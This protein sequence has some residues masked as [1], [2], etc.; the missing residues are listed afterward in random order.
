MA[1]R[2]PLV[3]VN[4]QIQQLQAGDNISDPDFLTLTND[5]AGS[6]PIGTPVYID[7]DD[8]A[9]KARANAAATSNVRALV[10]S[11]SISNG[12]SGS[13][14]RDGVLVATTGQWDTITGGSGGLVFNTVYYLDPSTAG[15]LTDTAPTTVGQLVVQVGVAL[16]TTEL[17][18]EIE[19]PILL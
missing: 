7:A 10:A 4:G 15:K 12:A 16:S 18:I 17:S 5:E 6:I 14:Q 19:P 9:K 1:I 13:F 3:M 8:G 2:K 11:T